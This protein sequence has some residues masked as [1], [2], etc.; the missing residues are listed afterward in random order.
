MF[1][2]NN[3]VYYILYHRNILYGK[4]YK[5]KTYSAKYENI[6]LNVIYVS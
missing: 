6:K 4:I 2:Y 3:A 5:I 1:F